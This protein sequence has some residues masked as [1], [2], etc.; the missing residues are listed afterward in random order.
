MIE[1]DIIIH[2]WFF[3]HYQ[4]CTEF[5]YFSNDAQVFESNITFS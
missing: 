1:G 5:W 2:A 4:L 3:F